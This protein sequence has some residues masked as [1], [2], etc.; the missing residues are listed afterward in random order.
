[1]TT[2][3]EPPEPLDYQRRAKKKRSNRDFWRA[4]A[5]LRPYRRV[6]VISIICALLTGALTAGGLLTLMPLMNVLV[7]GGTIAAYA[8]EAVA[9][10]ELGVILDREG[11]DYTVRKLT[12]RINVV[13]PPG[14]GQPQVGARMSEGS[15]R[16]IA[17]SSSSAPWYLRVAR[18]A[19]HR[20]PTDPVWAIA[21]MFSVLLVLGLLGSITRFFQEY[22]SEITAISAINDIR[23]RLY[24][25]MLHLPLGYFTRHGS[26]DLT[27]RLVSDCMGLQDGF[28]MILGKA[29]QEP[30]TATFALLAAM[31][32]DWRLTIFIIVFT[33]VMI[34]T[35]RKLGKRVRR[36]MRATLERNAA[37]LGQIESSFVGVRV[38]K[39]ATAEPFERRRYRAVLEEL[40]TQQNKMAKYDAWSTPLLEMLGLIAMGCVLLFASWL[41]FRDRT[42][43]ANELIPLMI[44]LVAIAEPLR[45]IS[46]LNAILQKGNA[47]ATRI[48]EIFN[49]PAEVKRGMSAPLMNGATPQR[50]HERG[51]R[52]T[53]E[54]AIS[55]DS[56]TFTY[57]GGS[58]PAL[59]NVNLTI[60]KGT[61]V[62][63]VGRNGSGKTT[64]LSLLP[65]FFEPDAGAILIDGLDVRQWPLRRLRRLIGI[66]TQEAVLFPGTIAQ[67]IA[68]ADPRIARERIIAAAE[69]AHA[70]DFIMQKSGGYD[71]V[72]EGL[73][74]Q[75][76]GGQRQRLNIARAILRDTPILILDEA[77]SQVDAESEHLIQGAI[78]ELMKDRTTFVIAH[79]FS[80]IL[81]ADVIVVMEQGRIVGTGKHDELLTTCE[82]YR[83]LYERQ[84]V[85]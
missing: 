8:D 35:I 22:L 28:K 43:N 74:G 33:P 11:V 20:M 42:L 51:A 76:S 17:R 58:A 24:D 68:Y 52:A 13:G 84:L 34:A 31:Y 61:S 44:C 82:T 67:N 83:Q 63:I 29:I 71:A 72:V 10:E 75:L 30:I 46:K 36:A 3:D 57:P 14:A 66:V 25:H 41:V 5:Y 39:S 80:T 50:Q 27:A 59:R 53:F 64:L 40:R 18:F 49:E 7:G 6:V 15:V 54:R 62:A 38:V 12:R 32:I 70:H 9:E 77:T 55:F 73:G 19:A 65:R 85:G 2:T 37:M 1:V 56:L 79:R 23:K 45:R 16:Q 21:A 48:F 47:A 26:S 69:R 4:T 78:A 60:S 81:S